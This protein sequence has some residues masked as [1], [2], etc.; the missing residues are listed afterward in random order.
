MKISLM[1]LSAGKAAGKALP[2]NAA[3][4]I[5][6]RDPLCNLRPSSTMISKKHCAVLVSG[7]QVLLR[8]FDSTNGTYV[9]DEQI[10]GDVPLKDGDVLRLGPLSFKVMIEGMP[11]PSMPTPKP[12]VA[13]QDA[14]S[15]G[16]EVGAVSMSETAQDHA[17]S[18]TTMTDIP[19]FVP[20]NSEQKL[21]EK[22]PVKT[23]AAQGAVKAILE[24]MHARCK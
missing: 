5:I 4:F 3:Q 15:V 23:G 14:L 16:E 2:I 22:A 19:T 24:K 13:H 18:D 12:K 6:G 7:G 8:D 17:L 11:V 1:V 21:A 9:N 10:K 20:P